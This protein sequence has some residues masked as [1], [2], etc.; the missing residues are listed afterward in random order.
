MPGGSF[1]R[2]HEAKGGNG[3][4]RIAAYAKRGNIN[5]KFYLLEVKFEVTDS[6]V[7]H[8]AVNSA[9]RFYIFIFLEVPHV[10]K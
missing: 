2:G 9:T 8:P 5:N 6:A 3:L 4:N 1:L 7:G 10:W